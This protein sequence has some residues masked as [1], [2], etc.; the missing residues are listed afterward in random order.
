[1]TSAAFSPYSGLRKDYWKQKT[2]E[3]VEIH[4]LR[5]EI[6]DVVLQSWS[7]IFSSKIGKASYVIGEDVFPTPQIM[8]FL[9]HELIALELVSRYP[10]DW[11]RDVSKDDK[12]LVCMFDDA[13]S[14]EIKA[15]S[16]RYGIFGNRSYA[17]PSS[18]QAKYKSGY[19]IAI[20]FEGLR[21][22]APKPKVTKIRMGWLEQSDWRGQKAQT[23]QQA[24]LTI[25]AR[26]LKLLQL[27]PIQ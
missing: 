8:A 7:D 3:L 11:R 15:S 9:L 2:V 13:Y 6:V 18:G 24:S 27:Y 5:K 16:S 26:E 17:Q 1:M 4:P 22:G 10:S 19:Y 25:D 21:R 23:G 20:N 12:D 14:T